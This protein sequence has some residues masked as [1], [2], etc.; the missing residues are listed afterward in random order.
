M[1]WQPVTPTLMRAMIAHGENRGATDPDSPLLRYANGRPITYRRY[2][3]IWDRVRR[4]LPWAYGQQIST[5]WLRHTTPTWLERHFGYAIA[6]AFAGHTDSHDNA[7]STYIKADIATAL[8]TLTGEPVQRG[9][10]G[11]GIRPC[12]NSEPWSAATMLGVEACCSGVARRESTCPSGRNLQAAGV[13]GVIHMAVSRDFDA[14]EA[15]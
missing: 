1:R 6:H 3:H 5:H 8:A 11:P 2:D 15:E 14:S 4:H 7:T 10:R 9:K 13:F 12:D